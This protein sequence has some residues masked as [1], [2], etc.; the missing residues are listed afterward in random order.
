MVWVLYNVLSILL[1]TGISG[2]CEQCCC[3]RSGTSLLAKLVHFSVGYLPRS[4]IVGL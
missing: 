1:L 4:G 3:E 2:N